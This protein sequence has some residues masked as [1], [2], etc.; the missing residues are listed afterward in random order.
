MR[1][2]RKETV[3]TEKPKPQPKPEPTERESARAA[4]QASMDRRY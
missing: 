4:L 3:V 2:T 1:A